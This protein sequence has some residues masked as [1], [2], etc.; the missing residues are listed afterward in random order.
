MNPWPLARAALRRRW[1][2][3]LTMALLIAVAT[4]LGVG[5]GALERASR[6]AA[7]QAADAFD[8]VI[9]A[10]GGPTQLVM[11][12]VYLKP[13]SVPLLD[14]AVVARVLAE[15][16]AAW[17]SPIGFGDSYQGHPVVGV[18]PAFIDR[19]GTR[20]LAEGKVFG[21]EEE[22]VVGA[23]V[24][25]AL[26]ATFSPVHG[27]IE[28]HE[29]E[30]HVHSE[31][32]YRIVG[33]LP[34]TGTPWDG[35][36]LVPIESVWEIHGLGNGHP[37]GVERVGPPW[38]Q[39]SGVPAIVVKPR[40]FAGAYQLRARYRT[41]TSTAVFPGEV[42]A[43]MFRTLG[44]VRAVLSGMAAATSVLV[45]VAV[46]LAFTALVA[47]RAREH[48]VLRALGAAPLFVLLALWLE[49]GVILA[50]GV[51]AGLALGWAAAAAAGSALGRSAGVAIDVGLGGNEIMLA[52]VTLLAALAAAALPAGLASRLSPATLL[53]R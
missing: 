36:I 51:V 26:G 19:A 42:L 44:D 16:E 20:S 12:S 15:K 34:P 46:F 25:L 27:L 8:L 47:G 29:H 1:L 50:A 17:S 48:A 41:A 11:A 28:A 38:E 37:P 53:K 21:Q 10:P 22:A 45:V 32:G 40:S 5:I 35:A 14:P 2:S 6:K 31:I 3:A 52:G 4:G 7:A 13:E 18:S 24:P 33:R 23:A 43:E 49:L 30:G 9:G 39:P